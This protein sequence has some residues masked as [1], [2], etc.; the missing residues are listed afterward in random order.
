MF[1]CCGATRE[2]HPKGGCLHWHLPEPDHYR[3]HKSARGS[4]DP[5]NK[6]GPGPSKPDGLGKTPGA[7]EP[8]QGSD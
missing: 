1:C 6:P 3:A 5:L 2:E 7:R 4:G 8:G